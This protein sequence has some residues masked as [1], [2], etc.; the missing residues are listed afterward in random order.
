MDEVIIE[1]SGAIMH[2]RLNRPK[3]IHALNLNMVQIITG[4]LLAAKADEACKCVII[5]HFDGRGF[6]AGGDI[7]MLKQS[8]A[9][10]CVEARAFFYAEYQMNHLIH[11]FPKPIIS[12]L[13]GI[14]M[15]GGVGLSIHGKYRIA[16]PNTVFA[17]P[18]TGIGL[19]PD[20]GGGWFLPRLEGH[21]GI[22][23]A[24][25][26]ARLK[27]G[28]CLEAKIATQYISTENIDNLKTNI[29]SYYSEQTNT[30]PNLLC[31]EAPAPILLNDD[32]KAKI[33]RH[34]CHE[35]IEDIF[36]SLRD[37]ESEWAKDTLVTLMAKSPQTLKIAL[38]QMLIGKNLADFAQN[39]VM[40][41]RIGCRV[42]ALNDFQE[43]VRA[44]I[45]DKDNR[46]NWLPKTAHEV[47][48]KLLDEIFA[49]LPEQEEWQP[50]L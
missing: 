37:D 11:Q 17:M 2:V 9:G 47:D 22:W 39:M 3:T 36:T 28:D 33:T 42:I 23:L 21:I 45:I 16:T 8:G 43:G 44:L 13:D 7:A 15:G 24:L 41:Y 18:E 46:P 34:F 25:T 1:K 6:C 49:P 30:P 14:T 20:V 10:D 29:A 4:A 19:F 48:D 27:A 50:L 32:N 12:F 26:G 40:E 5:D 35:T 38:K 31:E